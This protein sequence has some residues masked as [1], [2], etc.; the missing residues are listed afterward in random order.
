V[1]GRYFENCIE[2]VRVGHHHHLLLQR[3][4]HH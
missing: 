1:R 4:G 3:H 2:R